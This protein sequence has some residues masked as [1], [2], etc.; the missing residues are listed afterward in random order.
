ML[1]LRTSNK[2]WKPRD[3]GSILIGLIIAMIVMAFLAAGMVYLTSTSTIQ[4][5]FSNNHAQ[6]YYVAESGGRYALAVIRNAFAT[7]KT[8]LSAI[9]N[10]QT[11][12]LADNSGQFQIVNFTQD[13]NDPATITFTSIGTVKS[14][15]LQARRQ[16]LYRIQP[17]D[18]SG[19][20]RGSGPS[21]P[22]NFNDY[23][24]TA[25]TGGGKITLLPDG[26]GLE[27]NA[28]AGGYG[29]VPTVLYNSAWIYPTDY[30][31]QAQVLTGGSG[32]QN[33]QWNI[34][35]FF[36]LQINATDLPYGYGVTFFNAWTAGHISM[37]PTI[38][39]LP[40]GEAQKPLILLWQNLP[41]NGLNWIAY[42]PLDNNAITGIEGGTLNY[43][44]ILVKVI[45]DPG[46]PASNVLRVYFGDPDRNGTPDT[47]PTNYNNREGY[48]RW[49]NPIA[50]IKWPSVGIWPASNDYFTL[51]NSSNISSSAPLPMAKWISNTDPSVTSTVNFE[52]D[53]ETITGSS[54]PNAVIRSTVFIGSN[55]SGVGLFVD[56]H[57]NP[58]ADY[59]NLGIQ[60]LGAGSDGNGTVVVSP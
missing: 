36:N 37:N 16:L 8:K 34:G 4:Q 18:Q 38:P 47:I 60:A 48:P 43:P 55:Y 42:A 7:D 21:G 33:R 41:V 1:R 49:T 53:T 44:T 5:I 15:S 59:Y 28:A 6:A 14:G 22:I 27:I 29:K 39:T 52:T 13:N 24:P 12:L 56:A 40:P 35:L 10:N 54:I 45:R 17:A 23:P 19:G 57:A 2:P 32:P 31:A 20:T 11:F 3:K 46:P 26:S 30:A 50:D 51:I 58:K 9:N 25:I